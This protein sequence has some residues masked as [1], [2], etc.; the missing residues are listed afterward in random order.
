[1]LEQLKSTRVRTIDAQEQEIVESRIS[2]FDVLIVL[3]RGKWIWIAAFIGF[4]ILGW[5][6]TF[7]MPISYRAETDILPPQQPTSTAALLSTQLGGLMSLA[8][9]GGLG[10]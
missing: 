6:I 5:A 9:G 1:M 10:L 2:L 4:G 7:L 8:G 3:A